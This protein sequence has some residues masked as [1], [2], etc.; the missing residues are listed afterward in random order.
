[1]HALCPNP[2]A[3]S[4]EWARGYSERFGLVHVDFD[5][6]GRERYLKASACWY[7]TVADGNA[8]VS[9]R[10]FQQLCSPARGARGGAHGR[11]RLAGAQPS[12]MEAASRVREADE[13]QRFHQQV[14]APGRNRAQRVGDE[15]GASEQGLGATSSRI[16]AASFGGL[17]DGV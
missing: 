15:G 9:P 4:F 7:A 6:P 13:A 11:T 17:S 1:M 5:S 2:R 8:L 3:R 12:F 10:P 16:C 14:P